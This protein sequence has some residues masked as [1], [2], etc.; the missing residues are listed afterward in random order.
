LIVELVYKQQ[1]FG[2]GRLEG[3]EGSTTSESKGMM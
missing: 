1:A 3:I 2:H